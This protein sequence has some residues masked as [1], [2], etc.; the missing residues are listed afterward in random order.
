MRPPES[1]LPKDVFP[2]FIR[3]FV[4]ISL[5]PQFPPYLIAELFSH[6]I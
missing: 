6:E 1:E 3:A 2:F 5:H 4:E